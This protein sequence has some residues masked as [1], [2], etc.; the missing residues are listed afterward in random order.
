MEKIF[1]GYFLDHLRKYIGNK[2]LVFSNQDELENI[3]EMVG[4]KKWN[5]Y[6]KA[7]FGG[8]AQIIEYLG[9]YTHKVAITAHRIL[10]I[11]DSHISFKYKDYADG[12]KQKVMTLAHEVPID[13]G[14]TAI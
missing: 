12:H 6:A 4:Q 8:P 5:V 10:H 9:R 1:K 2:T 14:I 11:D 3:L 13:I 7:P